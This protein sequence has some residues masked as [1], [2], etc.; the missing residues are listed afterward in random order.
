MKKVYSKPLL[1]IEV[2]KLN[3][4]IAANCASHVSLG[5]EAPGKTVCDEF[6]DAFEVSSY[7]MRAAGGTPFYEDGAANCD[8]Y[9]SSGGGLYFTS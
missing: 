6:K 7:G 8:C 9:Y 2:Y 5:P 4:D 1:E 3:A